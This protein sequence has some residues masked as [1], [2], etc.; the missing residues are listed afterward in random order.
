MCKKHVG[1]LLIGEGNETLC[2][3]Q[4]F[5]LGIVEENIVVTVYKLLVQKKY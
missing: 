1:L 4:R 3:Y 2:S 5:L